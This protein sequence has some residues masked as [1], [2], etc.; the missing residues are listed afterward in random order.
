MVARRL[1]FWDFG[2]LFWVGLTILRMHEL[3]DCGLEIIIWAA[4]S[5][6]VWRLG[7]QDRE[8]MIDDSPIA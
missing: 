1:G 4:W 3:Y 5:F 6:G 8:A 7:R 2:I